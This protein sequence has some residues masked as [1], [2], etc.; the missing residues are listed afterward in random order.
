LVFK[1]G[2]PKLI[3]LLKKKVEGSIMNLSQYKT[4]LNRKSTQ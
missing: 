2:G 3:F 1:I 4:I